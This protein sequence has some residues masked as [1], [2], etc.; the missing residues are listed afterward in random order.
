MR[1]TILC[2]FAAVLLLGS[3]GKKSGNSTLPW[4][5]DS[6]IEKKVEA[7]LKQMTLDEKL[8]QMLQLNLP[9]V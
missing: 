2:A 3:C 7:T 9:V 1:R 4:T 8:G 6:E 5:Y